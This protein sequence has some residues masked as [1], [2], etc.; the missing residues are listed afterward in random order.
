MSAHQQLLRS[1]LRHTTSLGFPTALPRS[2]VARLP[3]AN[4]GRNVAT[5]RSPS[6][7]ASPMAYIDQQKPNSVTVQL[8]SGEVTSFHHVWLR[9]HCREERSCHPVTKQRLVDTAQI[10]HDLSPESVRVEGETLVISWP[11]TSAEEAYES[12]Y[13]LDF[14]EKHAYDPPL[15]WEEEGVLPKM[16]WTKD[17]SKDIPTVRYEEV[18]SSEQGVYEWV[19]RIGIFGFCF[20]KEIPPTPEATEAL[21]RRIAFIRETHYGAFWDFTADL[22]HGDLAYSDFYL[23][24]HTDTT[25]FSDPCGLQLFHLL[26][27]STSHKGGH[28]LLVDGFR[29]A[30][31]LKKERPDLYSLFSTLRV[32]SHASGSGSDS[33]PSGVHMSPLV[34]QPV[35]THDQKGELVQVRWNGDDRAPVGGKEFEGKMDKWFEAVRVWEAILRS[36]EAE[37]WTVMEQGTAIMFDNMRVL[38]G[39]SSFT[40]ERRLCGGYV[41]GDDFRSRLKGLHRQFGSQK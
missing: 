32:P 5:A 12:N 33:C 41:A 15:E 34:P 20:V 17:I 8:P 27:P 10:P 14:L 22:K 9:D 19:K 11:K 4:R 7:P 29:A 23:R 6:A 39:R 35:F 16:L 40:G 24:A 26:S 30:S 2:V 28:N 3:Q 18:M 31:I 13:P 25:Y 37:L 38:H 21:I 1:C 36:E